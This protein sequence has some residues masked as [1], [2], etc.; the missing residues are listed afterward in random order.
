MTRPYTYLLRFLPENKYYYGVRYKQNCHPDDLFVTYFTSSK[1]IKKLI[2]IHGKESFSFEIR[3]IFNDAFSARK[4]ETKVLKRIKAAQ[5][6]D[7]LNKTNNISIPNEKKRSE[8][9]KQ[10]IGNAHRGKIVSQST[11]D[12]ISE[13][14]KERYKNKLNHPM[15]GKKHTSET[16]NK[17]SKIHKNKTISNEQRKL[18]SE[19]S[20][21]KIQKYGDNL[22][23][24]RERCIW[25]ITFPNGEKI[26][27]K[28]LRQFCKEHQ[29]TAPSMIQVSKGN[30]K[31]HKN[32][33]CKK[34]QDL[35]N[36]SK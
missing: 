29:L 19:I 34:L 35:F 33:K 5:R 31:H 17:I 16:K 3:K 26:I 10:K 13:L 11:K 6:D 2:K 20:K 25:E 8:E 12:K 7:F 23:I 18:L 1:E 24:Y 4:W 36:L 32:Y 22:K 30:Q 27:T 15:Y 21:N 14:A 28:N 9:T